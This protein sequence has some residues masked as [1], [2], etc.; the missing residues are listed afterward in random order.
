MQKQLI[1]FSLKRICFFVFSFVGHSL[2]NLIIRSALSR[3][4]MAPLLPKLYTFLSLSGPH[5]G[6]LYN[7]SGLVNMGKCAR[8]VEQLQLTICN[9]LPMKWQWT[10][11]MVQLYLG[12]TSIMLLR[13]SRHV[14]HAE[15][16]EIRFLAAVVIERPPRCPTNIYLQTQHKARYGAIWIWVINLLLQEILFLALKLHGTMS[17]LWSGSVLMAQHLLTM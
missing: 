5:L 11:F 13:F 16:E 4:K 12:F 17:W 1:F 6:T 9:L 14:V 3:P 7:S 15:M 8:H 10:Y 2:G